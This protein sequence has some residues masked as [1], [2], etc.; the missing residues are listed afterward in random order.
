MT[1]PNQ[2]YKIDPVTFVPQEMQFDPGVVPASV[3]CPN[4]GGVLVRQP[5]V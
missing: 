3:V 2:N 5:W 4:D 1:P